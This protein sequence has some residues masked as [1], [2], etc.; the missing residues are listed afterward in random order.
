MYACINICTS[1]YICIYKYTYKYKSV[2]GLSQSH[3]A[4]GMLRLIRDP[5]TDER[6]FLTLHETGIRQSLSIHRY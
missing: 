5:G 6:I 4:T 3:Y 1:I 2:L